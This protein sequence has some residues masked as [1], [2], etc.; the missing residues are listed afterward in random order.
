MAGKVKPIPEHFHTVTPGLVFRNAAK[1]IDFYK[2]AFG[3]QE[4]MRMPGPDGKSIMHC[5]LKIGDSVLFI[6][7]ENPYSNVKSPETVGTS[8]A[9][10]YLYVE[11]VD[12]AFQRALKAGGKETMPVADM[13]WGDRFGTF[14]DPFGYQWGLATHV[15]DLTPQQIEEGQKKFMASMQQQHAKTA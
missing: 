14:V 9:S 5:E 13:F 10:V 11:D 7:D 15:A 3:A 8:T 2:Q 4:L 1:A 12:S 6:T